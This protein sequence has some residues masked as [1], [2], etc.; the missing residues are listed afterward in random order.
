MNNNLYSSPAS[1]HH[2][3]S[4]SS[5]SSRHMLTE[6]S[7]R[8]NIQ[9]IFILPRSFTVQKCRFCNQKETDDNPL[10]IPCFCPVEKALAHAACI[11]TYITRIH[12]HCCQ[13]CMAPYK[14]NIQKNVKCNMCKE[15]KKYYVAMIIGLFILCMFVLFLSLSIETE[16]S[17]RKKAYIAL[18]SIFLVTGSAVFIIS[19]CLI[20]EACYVK[21]DSIQ[22]MPYTDKEVNEM[23]SSNLCK[24]TEL[25]EE[26]NN[27]TER[28]FED[29]PM[30][31]EVNELKT[32]VKNSFFTPQTGKHANESNISVSKFNGCPN[33][34]IIINM[35]N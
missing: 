24:I 27:I 29:V 18:M 12:T 21:Q 8:S 19:L 4:N 1:T 6:A 20:R 3:T 35:N 14:L 9:N 13:D 22:V 25:P 10:I 23:R 7:P 11:Q 34:T 31:S 15:N 26:S 30:T 28:C 33:R 2:N 32:D 5:H 16:H 17:N